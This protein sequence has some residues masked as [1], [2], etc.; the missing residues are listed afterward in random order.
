MAIERMHHVGVIVD[1]LE[2]ATEFFVRVGLQPDGSGSVEGD[3]VDRIVG[4]HGVR[5]DLV[6]M[7]TP[8]GHSRVELV[9]F[10]A[11]AYEGHQADDAPSNEPGIRHLAF[12]VDDLDAT[13]ARVRAWGA[14]LV[15]EVVS[16]GSSY[17]SC[18]VRGP[19]GIIVEL[20]QRIDG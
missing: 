1:D 14:D 11:P 6:M 8:D 4:L 13:L 20:A 18:Y 16:Y 7:K 2:A 15:G 19:A 12:A 5:S 10:N 17:R 9:K 3:E